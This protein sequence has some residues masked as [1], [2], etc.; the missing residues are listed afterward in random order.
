MYR[1]LEFLQSSTV[2][3]KVA[4][5]IF[6][7]TSMLWI[8]SSELLMWMDFGN[9]SQSYK[10]GLSI[11]WGSYALLMIALGIW[12]NKRHL[13]MGAMVLFAGTLIKLFIYDIAHLNTIAKTI[14]FVSLGLLLLMISFLY[15]KYKARI[16]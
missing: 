3:Y 11:L 4:F 15:N 9:L 1:K 7:Y 10:L 8:A 6:F 16:L 2:N 14:V 12:K 5:D 13:R